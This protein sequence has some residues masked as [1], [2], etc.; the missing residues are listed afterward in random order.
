MSKTENK[1]EKKSEITADKWMKL[2]KSLDSSDLPIQTMFEDETFNEE[3]RNT[4]I[5]IMAKA[6]SRLPQPLQL[7]NYSH[8][9][10]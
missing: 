5:E 3:E 7:S 10:S 9:K 8:F 1:S 6:M 2:F 4:I